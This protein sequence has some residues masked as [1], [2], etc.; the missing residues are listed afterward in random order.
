V[1]PPTV[2]ATRPWHGAWPA[3]LG[4]SLEYP[5]V[6]AWWLL[7]RNL[8][9]VAQRVA[10]RE[11]DHATLAEGRTLTY[12]ALWTA[13]RGAAAGLRAR[14]VEPGVRVGFCLS[15]SAAL[16]IGYYATW[17]AGGVVVPAN[18][19]ATESEVAHQLADAGVALVIG[20]A[21]GVGATVAGALKLP[22]V[23]ASAF[24]AMEHERPAAP[25]VCAPEDVAVLLYTGGTT[26][27][28]KG[29]MLTHRNIVANTLQFAT[30]YAFEP[31]D[32]VA[33]CA[34]PMF[35]SGGMSGVMNVRCSC[36]RASRPHR[37]QSQSNASV[38]R[39]CS[40]CRPCSSRCSTT[41]PRALRTTRR[42]ARAGPMPRRYRR[43]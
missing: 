34:I 13:V 17:Y 42:F 41:P 23:D 6:P 27:A 32:E 4:H 24:Q 26:G 29:A 25:A 15:N 38:S 7:E 43:P 33:A 3:H 8:P 5:A 1:A 12:E 28:P 19:L 35:H 31:G 30:W 11:L 39:G 20:V 22:F 16:I 21:G 40:G 36:S 2:D 37:S 14:G 9:R 18:P 10:L